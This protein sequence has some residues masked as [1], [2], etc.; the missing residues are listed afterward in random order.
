MVISSNAWKVFIS[1]AEKRSVTDAAN[2]LFISQ[3]AVSKA[4]K[5]IEDELKVKLFHRDKRNGLLIT[6]VGEKILLLARQMMDVEHKIYQAAFQENNFLVGRIRIASIPIT[7][8]TI[9]SK[10]IAVFQNKYPLVKVELF[11][12][13][14]KEVK[15]CVEEHVVDFG[16]GIGP[17]DDLEHQVLVQDKMLCIS[18]TERETMLDLKE[19][20]GKVILCKTGQEAAI[21]RLQK[22]YNMQS[23]DWFIVSNAETVVGMATQGVGVGVI[24]EYVLST[25]P[26]SLF[27]SPV[28]PAI[29]ME[30]A[31]FAYSFDELT[32]VASEFISIIHSLQ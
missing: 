26:H 27:T 17:F 18:N 20:K 22:D 9:L 8:N 4:I 7:C 11:E 10:A 14:A 21:E 2:E 13:G 15:K 30:I 24:S 6:D 19:E 12:G 23:N 31:L 29:E 32:P 25:V 28:V 1:V 3:P 5:N 16:I